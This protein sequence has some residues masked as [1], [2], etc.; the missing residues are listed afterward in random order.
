MMA[1]AIPAILTALAVAAC[2]SPPPDAPYRHPDVRLIPEIETIEARVP[3]R[4]TL[5]GLLRD[6]HLQTNLVIAAVDAARAVFNPRDLR[7]DRPYK[8]VRSV[9]GLLREFEYQIDADR[10]LRIVHREGQAPDTLEA[11]VLPYEKQV[12]VTSID[13]HV[14][15]DHPSLIAAIDETG[16]N[17]QLALALAEIFG[18]QIDFDSDLQLGDEFRVL[19]EK[20][21]HDGQFSGYGAILGASMRVDGDTNE[22][23]R[24]TN[25]KTGKSGYYDAD[26]RSLKR[27]F[28]RTPL[29]FTPRITSGFSRHRLHPVYRTYRAHLGIDYGAPTGS[30][31][32]AAASGVVIYAHYKGANGNLVRI[33]H[34]KGYETYYLHLS[35][36]ARGIHPGVRVDQGQ[37]IGYVGSTGAATGPHLDYRLKKNGVFV[38]PLVEH[39]RMPPGDP[40]PSVLLA[41]FKTERDAILKK[42]PPTLLAEDT[43]TGRPDAVK[44]IQH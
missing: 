33:R 36:Y 31:V 22:A 27:F 12:E 30:P 35:R 5:D 18:G 23:F 40:I 19:F 25:P 7:A 14:D 20:T 37:V 28:L 43:T 26:G 6:N 1:R 44:A 13:A 17:V 2:A 3:A 9:D 32:V 38:N 42:L 39:R 8:L 29:K 24:W 11:E 15:D 16:E 10:F 41:D 34:A 21:S 4:A